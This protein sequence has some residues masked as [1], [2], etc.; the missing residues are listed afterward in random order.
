MTA[1]SKDSSLSS[2]AIA[3]DKAHKINTKLINRLLRRNTSPARIAGFLISNLVG[4]AIMAAGLQFYLDA[5]SLWEDK[6][7]FLKSDY[8]AIN[9]RVDAEAMWGNVSS[10]FSAEDIADLQAQPWVEKV[11]R[12]SKAD[13]RVYASVALNSAPGAEGDAPSGRR[14]STAMFFEAV[15]DE[16][17]DLKSADFSWR[18]DMPDI[19]IIISKDYLALYNFGFASSAGLPQLSENLISGLPLQLTLLSDDGSRRVEAYGRIVGYSNRFNTILVPKSMLD[20]YNEALVS[21]E[22]ASGNAD[23]GNASSE[24]SPS[25]R[26]IVDV[27]SP[28]DAAIAKYL[29][30]KGW[31]VAG[32]KNSSSAAYMLRVV[33]GVIIGVGSIITLLSLLILGLSMSL[34]MEKNRRKLHS[35]LMLGTRIKDAARPYW[36]LTAVS[37]IAAGLLA[38]ISVFLLRSYYLQP[39]RAIGAEGA[40]ILWSTLLIVLLT[41]IIILI[42]CR[43]IT[44]RVLSSWR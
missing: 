1:S 14:M 28:G 41:L 2:P 8:L 5:R 43:S 29:E 17:L 40:S 38:W 24:G 15:P 44:R 31:E 13:F 34:L 7:S 12:F 30:S 16:F 4:L 22:G 35:L 3:P 36:R 19:P 20:Y 18:P 37:A 25:S 42:N 33:S 26:L 39:L 21:S 27:N 32:D 11:G 10:D 9:K 23:N 6:D